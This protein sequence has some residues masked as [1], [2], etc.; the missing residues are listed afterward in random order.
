MRSAEQIEAIGICKGILADAK[1]LDEEVH[2]LADRVEDFRRQYAGWPWT[3]LGARL[4]RMLADGRIDEDE[5]QDLI[6]FLEAAIGLPGPARFQPCPTIPWTRPEP[7]LLYD[8]GPCCLAGD[9]IYGPGEKV[10]D[11]IEQE[12]GRFT[13]DLDAARYLLVGAMMTDRWRT[14]RDA[15]II[16]RADEMCAADARIAI[17]SEQA[18]GTTLT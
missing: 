8:L 9:F 18:W 16:V 7:A 1:L 3:P 11:R 6:A 14:M 13:Q 4:H 2:F 15:W 12:G 5:R 10:R 17:I